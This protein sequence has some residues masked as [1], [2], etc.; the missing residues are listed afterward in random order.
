M[1]CEDIEPS[2]ALADRHKGLYIQRNLSIKTTHC[3]YENWSPSTAGF[4]IQVASDASLTFNILTLDNNLPTLT[5][6]FFKCGH[7]R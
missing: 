5:F 4:F 7:D 3:R 1:K 6:Q 2:L